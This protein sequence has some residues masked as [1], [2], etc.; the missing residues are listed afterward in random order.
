MFF[1][2]AL[3]PELPPSPG[4]ERGRQD[5]PS[6]RI[7]YRKEGGEWKTAHVGVSSLVAR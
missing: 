7:L 3:R 1:L 2:G 5:A 6:S 4:G